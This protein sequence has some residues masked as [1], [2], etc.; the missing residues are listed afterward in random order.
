MEKKQLGVPQR[1]HP[2]ELPLPLPYC[3]H[4]F[5]VKPVSDRLV[6]VLAYLMRELKC[7]E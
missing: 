7:W 6:Y 4:V 2:V 5:P 3:D 1:E